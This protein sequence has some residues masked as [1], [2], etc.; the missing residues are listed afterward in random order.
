MD[1]LMEV[2]RPQGV[3]SEGRIVTEIK[4]LTSSYVMIGYSQ[5][6]WVVFHGSWMATVDRPQ[7]HTVTSVVPATGS[8]TWTADPVDPRTIDKLR[9]AMNIMDDDRFPHSCP[10][11]KA[12]AYVGLNDIDCSRGC[13]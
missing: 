13:A 2:M 3:W 9:D 4:P 5:F 8:K 11:C 7:Q 12:P 1:L 10:R 6:D